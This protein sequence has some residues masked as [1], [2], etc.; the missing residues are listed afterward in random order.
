MH[1]FACSV[2]LTAFSRPISSSD[3]VYNFTCNLDQNGVSRNS[4]GDLMSSSVATGNCTVRALERAIGSEWIS[5]KRQPFTRVVVA[6]SPSGVDV[7]GCSQPDAVAKR[8][9]FNLMSLMMTGMPGVDHAAGS[10]VEPQIVLNVL[11]NP[12]NAKFLHTN[13]SPRQEYAC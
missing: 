3:S 12:S 11:T 9:G 7:R 4:S 8:H 5:L 10:S 13:F 2:N 1:G 6:V